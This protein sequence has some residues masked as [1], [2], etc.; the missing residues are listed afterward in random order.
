MAHKSPTLPPFTGS[1]E[2]DVNAFARIRYWAGSAYLVA[3]MV[4]SITSVTHKAQVIELGHFGTTLKGLSFA[5]VAGVLY[6]VAVTMTTIKITL[7]DAAIF[8]AGLAV[9]VSIMRLWGYF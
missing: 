7:N 4:L 8:M 9:L 2:P 1:Q 6:F 5:I 3:S